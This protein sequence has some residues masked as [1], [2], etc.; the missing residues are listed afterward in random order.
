MAR[1]SGPGRGPAWL[2]GGHNTDLT[3]VS[4]MLRKRLDRL[5]RDLQNGRRLYDID[6]V[7]EEGALWGDD[8]KVTFIKLF[9]HSF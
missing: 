2:S 3:R 8:E 7:P 9:Q 5:F 1:W 4:K 6:G